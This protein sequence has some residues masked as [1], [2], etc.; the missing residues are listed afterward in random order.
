M[1]YHLC[2]PLLSESGNQRR[3]RCFV[4]LF[5]TLLQ[6]CGLP[7]LAAQPDFEAWL[8]ELRREASAEGIS[9]ATLDAALNG[10]QPIERVIELDRRQP[11]FTQTFW[12]YLDARIT[13]QRIKQG[14]KMLQ[15]HSV[16]LN[17]MQ[18]RYG[19]PARYLVAFWG[20]E[21]NY[22]SYLGRMPTIG[23]LA[24]LAYDRRRSLFF[25]RQLMAALRIIDQEQIDPARMQ[26]SWAGAIGHL[27]FMPSTFLKHAVDADGDAKRDVWSSLP[28]V[29]AS[30]ANYL[31][32]IGWQ[33]GELW[34]REVQLP[35][36][37]DWSLA[38]LKGKRSVVE[39]R[40]MGVTKADGRPLP[41]LDLP[42][43]VILPQGHEGP[44]FMVYG[45][46]ENI[47]QWNRSIFYAI[48]VGHLADRIIDLPSIRHG[49]SADNRQLSRK[50]VIEMQQQL[51][52]LG[53]Y[54]GDADGILGSQTRMAVRDYQR[55]KGLPVDGYPSVSLLEQLSIRP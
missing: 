11:E 18:S 38:S 54:N 30:G 46:F 20:L 6:L 33:Q 49:R 9:H 40:K 25:R 34:G 19:V 2:M 4:L 50:Q 47:L 5:A 26:G 22:G 55:D 36:N 14:K 29:F 43:A 41:P 16:L 35:D 44:A 10:I 51:N 17:R 7:V 21:T 45:N 42:A 48:A 24:T 3:L 37:F 31:S 12:N 53:F 52:T 23:A 39:W 13:P 1:I 28:D 15:Q 32:R 27:Q 8:A